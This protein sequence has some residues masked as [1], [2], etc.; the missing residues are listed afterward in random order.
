MIE[1]EMQMKRR[2][3]ITI[4]KVTGL[5]DV[6]DVENLAYKEKLSTNLSRV[7][8]ACED[9]D[10]D[11]EGDQLN[12]EQCFTTKVVK[13][14]DNANI[15]SPSNQT[16]INYA[17]YKDEWII[18]FGCSHVTSDDSLFSELRQHNR[19][20]VIVTGDNSTYSVAEEGAVKIDVDE[21]SVKL[22]DVYHVPVLDNVKNVVADV[23]LCGERKGSLFVMSVG[24][25]YV[26]K[27]SQMDS[28][29]TW[30]ARLGHVGY[31]MLQQ[32][33]SKGLLDG[34]PTLKNVHE[35][36]V[37][38]GSL[39]DNSEKQIYQNIEESSESPT[40]NK[41]ASR[42]EG[43][44]NIVRRSLREKRQ[45][46]HLNGYEVQLNHCSITSCLFA[47]AS[48]EEPECYKEAKGCL[49]WETT[50][51]DEIEALRR[52]D[53]WELVPKLENSQPVTCKWVYQLKKKSNGTIDHYKARLVARG[54]PQSYRLDYEETFSP[55]AKMV[56]V[57]SIF[58]LAAFKS[59]E[60]M[61]T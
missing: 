17:N 12:W 48:S 15:G 5:S 4:L 19:K 26:K 58:S 9:N 11:N 51:Q 49:E 8:V 28:A 33:F 52:N 57:R 32:I 39:P 35:D 44:H 42:R 3:V 21:T 41:N 20:R 37:C 36:V 27:T 38:Q 55:V 60:D 29:A 10:G 46:V 34:L 54:F 59:L 1:K 30:H 2:C 24:E 56:T 23:I 53:T 14:S 50:M 22:D 40:P 45:P 47:G 7:N 16:Q 31:Q 61:A 43:D 6:T 25:A 13:E 18:D